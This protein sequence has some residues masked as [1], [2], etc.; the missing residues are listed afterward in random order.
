MQN[1]DKPEI[2]EALPLLKMSK[3]KFD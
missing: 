3:E 1:D 2:E